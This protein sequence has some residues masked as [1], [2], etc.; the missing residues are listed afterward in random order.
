MIPVLSPEQCTFFA[1]NGYLVLPGAIDSRLCEG[2]LSRVL[3]DVAQVREPV[4][5]EADV[6]Y[7]GSP[8]HRDAEGGRTIRRLLQ[9][10]AR[11]ALFA[12]WFAEPSL[13]HAL[14]QLLGGAVKQ[15][16]AHHNC[17]MTKHP[18]YSSD[19]GWHQDIRYWAFEQ[20][21]LVSVWLA[22][23]REYPENGGLMVIPGTHRMGFSPERFD[24]R[25]FLRPER[26]E[27]AALIA[28]AVHVNLDVGDVLLFHARLF[29][30][31]SRNFTP[32]TKYSVVATYRR[33]D[34]HPLPG[35]RSAL[36]D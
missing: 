3:A 10:Y 25:L 31:A 4:E 30:A 2:M 36:N 11:D 14:E 7:P 28:Q 17:V 26:P 15:S 16:K 5:F 35:T 33:E 19:T 13:L 6:D 8:E 22:L 34:N 32:E 21:E 18:R 29:H 27:N 23:G 9:A 20:P 24:E 12:D 1:Q